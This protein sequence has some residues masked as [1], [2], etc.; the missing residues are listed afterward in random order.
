[1]GNVQD[2]DYYCPICLLSAI[3]KF[4]VRVILNRIGRILKDEQSCEHDKSSKKHPYNIIIIKPFLK[5]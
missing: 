1:M 3:Y 5:I 4:I 2:T